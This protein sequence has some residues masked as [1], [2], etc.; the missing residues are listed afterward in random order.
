YRPDLFREA[1]VPAPP[2]TWDELAAA[3]AKVKT[4]LAPGAY[5]VLLP[6]DEW[7][8][9]AVLGAQAGSPLL[10]EGGRYGAFREPPFRRAAAFYIS[11]FT[12]GLAPAVSNAQVSNVYQQIDTGDFAGW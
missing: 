11:L 12:R 6:T 4:V 10:R 5:P 8:Q 7:A 9:P 1:G 2:K 3:L